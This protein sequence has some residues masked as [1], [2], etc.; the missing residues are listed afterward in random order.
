MGMYD[1]FSVK[2]PHPQLICAQGHSLKTFQTKDF[3][4]SLDHYYLNGD[5]TL[6]RL[7]CQA[8]DDDLPQEAVLEDVKFTVM[9][10]IYTDCKECETIYSITTTSDGRSWI[11]ERRPNCDFEAFFKKGVLQYVEPII[12]ET[13]EMVRKYVEQLS[14]QSTLNLNYKI[15]RKIL[16]NDDPAVLNYL[17]NKNR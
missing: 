15:D 9:A 10:N 5:N 4:C 11:T 12:L 6:S 1:D 2:A 13:P 7:R 16:S 8:Y 17:K 3:E 14:T